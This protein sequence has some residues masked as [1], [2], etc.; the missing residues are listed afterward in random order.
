MLYQSDQPVP[1]ITYSEGLAI[2]YRHFDAAGIE[3]RGPDARHARTDLASQPRFEFG[4]GLSYTTFDYSG[5]TLSHAGGLE[6]I[7][8]HSADLYDVVM[9]ASFSIFNS[10]SF[11]GN[12]VPQVRKSFPQIAFDD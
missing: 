8:L 3:V 10:G 11:G 5:L 4:F 9:V 12:A 2:D 1:Q 7:A 6:G